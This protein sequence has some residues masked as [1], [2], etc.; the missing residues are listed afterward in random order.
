[1]TIEPVIVIEKYNHANHFKDLKF[2]PAR[3]D[4]LGRSVNSLAKSNLMQ[5]IGETF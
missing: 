3:H 2:D 4:T 1:M 5:L